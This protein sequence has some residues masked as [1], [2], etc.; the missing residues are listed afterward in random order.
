MDVL[1]DKL[2]LDG[3]EYYSDQGIRVN[4]ENL[5]DKEALDLLEEIAIGLKPWRKGPFYLGD[6][7]IDTEW[8]SYI[9]W[10]LIAPFV[11]LEGKD[12]VDIGCNNGYYLFEM[13]KMNPK[14]LLGFDPSIFYKMQFDFIN[15]FLKQNITYESLGVEDIR[16]YPK[17]FD[18]IF[19]LG[20]LYHRSDPIAGLKSLFAGLNEG[21]ELILDTLI[22]DSKDEVALCPK[23]TYAK[24]SNVYF[25]PS[26]ST[27]LGWGERVGFREMQILGQQ[28]TTIY[29]QRKTKWIDGLSLES[30]LDVEDMSKTIEGY[31]APKRAYFKFKRIKNG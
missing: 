10:E 2:P 5:L 28:E 3:F 1:S 11:Q 22:I 13:A 6:L 4:F 27:L 9:K 7:F 14:S 20:V 24:M 23:K 8:R 25:I 31:P 19:C 26:I 29:E 15:T 16:H 17:K 21:G 18:V 12:V 30:F